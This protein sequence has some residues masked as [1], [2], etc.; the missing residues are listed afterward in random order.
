LW[1]ELRLGRRVELGIFI[2]KTVFPIFWR[3]V[4]LVLF[5]G[6]GRSLVMHNARLPRWNLGLV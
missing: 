1:Q 2:N 5:C 3:L 6:T 4:D